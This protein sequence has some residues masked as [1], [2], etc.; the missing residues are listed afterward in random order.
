MIESKVAETI[1][2]VEAFQEGRSDAWNVPREEGMVLHEIVLASGYRNLVE[3]GTSYGFSGL[4]LASAARANG[5]RL[6]TFDVDPAKVETARKHFSEAGLDDVIDVHE[7]HAAE[8]LGDVDGAFDFAFID[9]AKDQTMDYWRALEPRMSRR[10]SVTV[11]NIDSE[12]EQMVEFLALLRGRNDM[13]SCPVLVGNG[14]EW[15][16]RL[17]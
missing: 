1:S 14:F 11:D 3:I 9:A 15:A 16:V 6:H 5:G 7:G 4:F 10:C 17:A 12:A 8:L 13:T 2:R